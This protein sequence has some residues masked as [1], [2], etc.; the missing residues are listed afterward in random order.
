M[1]FSLGKLIASTKQFVPQKTP[2]VPPSNIRVLGR[3]VSI[4]DPKGVMSASIDVE[5]KTGGVPGKKVLFRHAIVFKYVVVSEVGGTA[6]K[7]WV[8]GATKSLKVGGGKYRVFIMFPDLVT[9]MTKSGVTPV[10][11]D[12]NVFCEQASISTSPVK[13]RCDCHDFRWRFAHYDYKAG[14][15]YGATPP[16]Y[17]RKTTTRPPANPK[18]LPGI[19][20]HILN[21]INIMK[22]EGVIH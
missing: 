21:V 19:C 9:D 6:P 14:C 20:K 17:K 7:D 11:I 4:F 8:A 2:R 15:L 18:G 12:N 1:S 13:V 3:S 16:I 5:S 22:S 10:E